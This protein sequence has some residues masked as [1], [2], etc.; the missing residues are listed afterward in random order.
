[1]SAGL[2]LDINN[3]TFKDIE[4]FFR[5]KK[6]YTYNELE[7]NVYE[8]RE[9]LLKSGHVDKRFKKDLIDFLETAK[10]WIS[11]AKFP[12]NVPTSIPKN[13]KLD[14]IDTPV[15][16]VLPSSREVN[17]I[18][19]PETQFVH[20]KPDD[21][22]PGSLNPLTTR[23]IMK[24]LTIDT[25]FR[26]NL[27]A[28]QSSDFTI[29]LPFKLSKVVQMQLSSIEIPVAFYGIS[30]SYGNNYF[31]IYIAQNPDCNCDTFFKKL[32]VIPDGN[33]NADDLIQLLNNLLQ[34]DADIFD[35]LEFVLD[36][37]PTGSGTGKVT[38][39]IIPNSTYGSNITEIIL[40]FAA[41]INGQETTADVST[42]FG[43]NLG[44]LKPKYEFEINYTA[45][46][47]IEPATIRYIY[48]AV[49]DFNNS[50]NNHFISAFHDSILNPN[51][52]A[53]ISIKGAYF[54]LLMENDLNIVSEPRRYF[55][56][57]DIQRLKIRLYDQNGRILDMNNANFSFCLNFKLLYDL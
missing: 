31:W 48:L 47:L 35:S 11:V 13:Y 44:F 1:M 3:Y 33:Y 32:F 17:L 24:C 38:L 8:I 10:R 52:L 56:P 57:V 28:T 16:Q 37:S 49:E 45:D 23:T 39:Q 25:K 6:T 36:I 27:Y 4:R 12:E 26:D 21:I 42:K 14:P 43:W 5:L 22:F 51:I 46:T 41:D 19:R 20:T 40:D 9:T 15:S 18:Q 30:A 55:G 2:D 7:K 50:V 29:Q 53:R 34:K 54:S